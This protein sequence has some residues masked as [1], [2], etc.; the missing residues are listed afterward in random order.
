MADDAPS[1][2]GLS[3][4]LSHEAIDTL[5]DQAAPPARLVAFRYDGTRF[6]EDEEPSVEEFDFR[7]PA[8][9]TE[10]E[11]RRVRIRNERCTFY[12]AA[13][14]S[15]M[16]RMDIQMKMSGLST[17]PYAQFTESLP[18]PAFI[19][20]FKLSGLSGVGILG[21]SPRLAMTVVDRILGGPGHAVTSERYLSDLEIALMGDVL[22]TIL[23]EWVR[24]WAD[25]EELS[26]SV[27]GHE[28]SGRFLQTAASDAVMLILSI[29][30]I[31]GDCNEPIHI[32]LPYYTM[33][34]LIR[35]MQELTRKHVGQAVSSDTPAWH[36]SYDKIRV[37]LDA[38]WDAFQVTLKDLLKLK[39][40]DVLL[41]PENI[42]VDTQVR[43]NGKNRF[44]GKVGVAQDHV[45]VAI[46]EVYNP[47][48]SDGHE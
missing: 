10:T 29:D 47:K 46:E 11:M 4:L 36:R 39:R 2:D 24:Q 34:P 38:E 14:L 18:D 7:N 48:D 45:T 41:L 12:L 44:R 28:N 15:M 20:T 27:V 40:G 3:D 17:E 42:A 23:E 9:L 43:I 33:E 1:D 8:F 26:P 32:G 31:M 16:L 21:I 13:R 30:T 35:K 6:R 19:S 5:I 22:Q 37:Q 25:I